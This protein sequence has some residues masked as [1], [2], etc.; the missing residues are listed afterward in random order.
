MTAPALVSRCPRCGGRVF[1]DALDKED[2]CSW[3]GWRPKP[4]T[5]EKQARAK[6]NTHLTA[7][8]AD[9]GEP[10]EYR[11]K[12]CVFCH[13]TSQAKQGALA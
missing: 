10:V 4:A 6:P 3:C 8:C 12:R 13:R 2:W 7:R 5:A 11:S 1:Y 9:C